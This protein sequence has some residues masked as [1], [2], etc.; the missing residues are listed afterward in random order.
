VLEFSKFQT[1]LSALSLD[2]GSGIYLTDCVVVS[3][4]HVPLFSPETPVLIGGINS[5]DDLANVKKVLLTVY[6]ADYFV[7]I[8]H[9]P[10]NDSQTIEEGDLSSID[11][12]SNLE[13]A[14]VLYLPPQL[15]GTSFE[16]LQEIMAHLREPKGC[17][18]DREQTH[19][20][21]RKYLLEE[22]YET[23]DALDAKDPQKMCEEFGDLLLQIVFHAQIANEHGDF[24]MA[25][26]IK[27]IHDKLV[28]RHP[29]VFGDVQ[30]DGARNVLRNW[31]KI[32]AEERE[33]NGEVE[34]G[35]LDGLPAALPALILAHEYQ[36]R[37]ARVGFDWPEIEGVLDK[38]KEEIEEIKATTNDTELTAEIGD[39]LFALVN[40]ARWKKI[41][42]EAALRETNIKFKRRFSYIQ[43]AARQMT[44]PLQELSLDE[45]EALWQEAKKS[46]K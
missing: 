8:I 38:V 16:R 44:R 18:W 39:L 40:L 25:D 30:V 1:A 3:T 23:L 15:P 28:R 36:S 21:L 46:E 7:R 45:M 5:Q 34:K 27:G 22:T 37:A 11:K 4:A 2:I 10:G 6:P 42:A 29:H 13:E 35:L 33:L 9:A 32:K 24:A 43:Q 17:P 20:S 19:L 26:I 31:E 12:V 14:S 41:D